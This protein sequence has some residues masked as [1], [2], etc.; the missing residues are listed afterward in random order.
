[1]LASV[2]KE[3]SMFRMKN[4]GWLFVALLG[5]VA[6]SATAAPAAPSFVQPYVVGDTA[7][8]VF[9]NL[10]DGTVTGIHVEFDQAVTITYKLEIGGYI[11]ALGPSTGKTFDFNGG[12][13]VSGGSFI[14]QWQPADAQP[15][16]VM[17]MNGARPVGTP[18]F[19]TLDKLG[20]LF[21]QGIVHLRQ[22]NPAALQA[23]FAEFFADNAAY[24]TQL[25]QA[26][27][28]SL[29]DSLLPVIMSAPAEG[30]QNFFNTIVGML[31][32]TDLQGLLGGAVDFSS[33][34]TALGL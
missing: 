23:A 6:F 7:A 30:I 8:W 18:Y 9:N 27:G 26:L 28:M 3:D 12:S 17:W 10:T 13:L 16:L 33:L 34:M 14:L 4:V 5:A 32:V 15:S 25:S 31:G 24:F 22:A 1:M 20:Y 29:Q 19:S 2:V 21:G 11:P